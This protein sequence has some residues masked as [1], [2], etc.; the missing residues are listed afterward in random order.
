MEDFEYYTE[1][2]GSE[3][4]SSIPAVISLRSVE[5]TYQDDPFELHVPELVIAK[6]E[7]VALTGPSGCGKTTLINLFAGILTPDSGQVIIDSI[8]ITD[9][10]ER[11]R[12][13]FRIA[14]LGL[15]FQEFELLD[16]LS[17]LDNIILPYRINPVL[18]MSKDTVSRAR[19]LCERV[20]LGS[21]MHKHP[22]NM[23]Q[24]ER[25]QYAGLSSPNRPLSSVTN[26][27]PISTLPTVIISWIS[28]LVTAL[29][30]KRHWSW[31]RMT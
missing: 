31:S 6:G 8:E 7:Q 30:S 21:Q 17:V 27:L 5:F 14:S 9:Y 15:I 29:I 3:D 25:Q 28:F 12:A 10:N 1:V 23:S 22:G 2:G 11:D 26:R 18:C 13:D 4:S 19:E 16:Y 20:G 24:G